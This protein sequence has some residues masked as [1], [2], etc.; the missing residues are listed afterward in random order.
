VGTKP[1][2]YWDRYRVDSIRLKGWNYRETGTYFITICTGSGFPFFGEVLN[3]EVLRSPVGEVAQQY[4]LEIPR[5][6]PQVSLDEFVIMPNPMHGII[7][8][9]PPEIH[10]NIEGIQYEK[11]Q[12]EEKTSVKTQPVD[13]ISVDK[14]SVEDTSV[15]TQHAASLQNTK[16]TQNIQNNLQ[17]RE[18]VQEHHHNPYQIG[19]KS[20]PKPGSISVILR[21]YKSA[22][23]RWAG[24]N[25]YREFR[26]QA[27]F[28]DRIVRDEAALASMR[29]YIIENPHNW[30][31]DDYYSPMNKE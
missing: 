12:L 21:S 5:H 26:W 15:E 11:A 7:I 23:S 19:Q 18:Q 25:G 17:Y 8:I 22:V 2:K 24:E 14:E 4:W 13:A 16:N 29:L 9:N 10:Q 30:G 28:Y 20:L 31:T 27:R 1:Q 3:G 6:F